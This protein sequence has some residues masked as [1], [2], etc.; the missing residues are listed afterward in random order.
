MTDL[1]VDL[2]V[3]SESMETHELVTLPHG[4]MSVVTDRYGNFY[5]EL[6]VGSESIPDSITIEYQVCI[7]CFI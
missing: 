6:V 3:V 4:S 2:F 7:Q 5:I 1:P